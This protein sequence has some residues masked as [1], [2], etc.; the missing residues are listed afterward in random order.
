MR[1]I[2]FMLIIAVAFVAVGVQFLDGSVMMTSDASRGKQLY[3]RYCAN[4]HGLDGKGEGSAAKYL[5]PKPRDFTRGLFKFQSTP[6]GS[7]PT[8][9]DLH[10]TIKNGMPGSAMPAWDRLTGQ[11][12]N[13]LVAYIKTYSERFQT[14]QPTDVLTIEKE[15]EATPEM[16]QDGK[17]V[18]ALAGCWRCHGKTGA[19]DGPSANDLKDDL[20]RPIRPYNFTRA[21]AFK[22]GGTPRDIYQTFS[23]GIGGTPMPGYGEDA[24]T[25]TIESF[26]DLENLEG[27]Y[28]P[29]EIHD[30]RDY[31]SKLPS[32][33]EM[34][35]KT[36]TE[37]KAL[38]DAKRWVLVY[39]VLS[40]SQSGKSQISYTITDHPITA[41]SVKDVSQFTDPTSTQWSDIKEIELA[42]IS[43]WQRE[44]PTDRVHVK[45][46]TDRK[47]IAFR[48][49]WEDP[50]KDDNALY[51]AKFGDAAAVQFPLDPTTDPFFGMGDTNFVVNIWHWKSWWEKDRVEYAGVTSAFPDMAVD[52]YPFD[53]TGSSIAEYF[54]SRDSAKN[55]SM[56]WNAG[57]GSGNLLSA[58]VRTSSVEDLN[59]KG[60][61]TLT[62]QAANAQNVKGKGI[63]KDGKWSVVLYR[64]LDSKEK[65]DVVLKSSTTIPVA[66]AVWDGSLN[67]RNGQK[68]VTNWYRLNIVAK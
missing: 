46:V 25:L 38:A 22:G 11:E 51:N 6:V 33:V 48:L 63:W 68:M 19:G 35:T 26:P 27:Q 4:C 53:V 42:L 23:T 30:I 66:F 62:S 54:V 52:G 56:T 15:P 43:L 49:E 10:R 47:S 2:V 45:C 5:F 34:N 32:E 65:D 17:A 13:D 18:Y 44:T 39:Y 61:G 59:A 21:G 40:L 57:W 36:E 8:D 28:T 3:E 12:R 31:V 20:E 55:I 41:V 1:R 7:L 50:T 37:R 29:E 64:S 24:L 58:Q 16:L 67:D 60:F 14:E 9:E